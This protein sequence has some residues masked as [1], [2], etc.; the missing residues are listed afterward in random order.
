MADFIQLLAIVG[1]LETL[2]LIG[3]IAYAVT[4]WARGVI[5]ALLRLGNGLAKRKIAIFAKGDNMSSLTDLLADS[6][7]FR[8]KNICEIKKKQDVGR[9]EG[10]SVYL[11]F[12]V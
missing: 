6:K 8:K 11:V 1:T 5:P 12:L 10:A 7:L 3:G 4:L 9:A 2:V